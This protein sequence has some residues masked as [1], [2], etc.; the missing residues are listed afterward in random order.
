MSSPLACLHPALKDSWPYF[1]GVKKLRN[2]FNISCLLQMAQALSKL[3][4]LTAGK[5]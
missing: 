5:R 1:G 4:L 3:P 2:C